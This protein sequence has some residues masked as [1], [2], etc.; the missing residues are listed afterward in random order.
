MTSLLKVLVVVSFI[1]SLIGC[2]NHELTR[3]SD[4]PKCNTTI[5]GS[6]YKDLQSIIDPPHIFLNAN[7]GQKLVRGQLLSVDSS[8]VLF[9]PDNIGFS[10]EDPTY[11]PYDTLYGV[12][13]SFGKL[14]YGS[15][16]NSYVKKHILTIGLEETKTQEF[17]RLILTPNEPFAYCINPGNYK[18]TEINFTDKKIQDIGTNFPEIMLTIKDGMV[19]YIGNVFVD[20]RKRE[21]E[22][23]LVI[24]CKRNDEDRGAALGMM[25]G[26][27]GAVADAIASEIESDG[28]YHIINI[29]Q[30]NSFLPE[31]NKGVENIKLEVISIKEK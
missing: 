12:I 24:P 31:A 19:N 23:V 11:Y 26:V 18:I 2:S 8:G 1:I 3:Y 21:D 14:I 20:K 28:L 30:E 17:S 4:N 5:E 6:Y 27:I 7:K 25:F 16:P 10:N 9:D 22:N 29:E 13:D 15:I